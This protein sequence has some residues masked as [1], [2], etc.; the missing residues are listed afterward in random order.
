MKAGA[1]DVN[2]Q[3]WLV[4]STGARLQLDWVQAVQQELAVTGRI[5]FCFPAAF[6]E[7]LLLSESAPA[8]LSAAKSTV[9][10]SL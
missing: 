8:R 10:S 3:N 6:T 7:G 2:Q 4:G 1:V 5:C 9:L